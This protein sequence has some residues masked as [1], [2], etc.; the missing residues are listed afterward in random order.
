MDPITLA[1]ISGGANILG[2]YLGNQAQQKAL[3]RSSDLIRGVDLPTAEDLSY[4][5]AMQS[6]VGD[7]TAPDIMMP[8]ELQSAM[9]GIT[10][11]PRFADAQ[12]AA[13]QGYEDI[14]SGGGMTEMDR[15]NAQRAM[16]DAGL[17]STR[18][19]A[20][21][22]QDMARRG[23]SGGGQEML[24][25][26]A[27]SQS[28]INRASDAQQ[29]IQAEARNRALQAL[30]AKGGMAGQMQAQ[31]FGQKSQIASAQDAINQFNTGLKTG[32]ANKLAEMQMQAAQTNQAMR[33]GV[34]GANTGAKN[35]ASEF[36]V[37]GKTTAAGMQ[38][39][40]AKALGGIE[41]QKGQ[42]ESNLYSGIGSGISGAV[43][44]LI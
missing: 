16:Q 5:P 13:L 2:G 3:G 41:G 35:R 9:S 26:L 20:D 43:S 27:A 10:T 32:Q 12:F 37:G 15:L 17:A 11:D 6:Y 28:N 44:S 1:A 14:I 25:K 31:Q 29:N 33:Q 22:Q 7:I 39:D 40:K 18:A 42:A 36:N 19:Q 4:D 38:M 34:H 24:A 21:I 30:Q 23:I 8:A